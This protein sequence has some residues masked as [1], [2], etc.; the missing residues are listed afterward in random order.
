[1]RFVLSPMF[2]KLIPELPSLEFEFNTKTLYE[3]IIALD[4]QLLKYSSKKI[5][6]GLFNKYG[7][8]VEELGK[9][10]E[11]NE[12]NVRPM[13]ILGGGKNSWKGIVGGVLIVA[14]TILSFIP[15]FNVLGM[16]MVLVGGAFM[17]S[18]VADNQKIPS[19]ELGESEDY[20]STPT[21][22]FSGFSNRLGEQYAVP[23]VYGYHKVAPT[24]ID[25]YNT[26]MYQYPAVDD[27]DNIV[28]I[29]KKSY[30]FNINSRTYYERT[31]NPIYNPNGY[32]YGD[33]YDESDYYTAKY[34]EY[35]CNIDISAT[36]PAEFQN[37]V[38]ATSL[39]YRIYS[40]RTFSAKITADSY[41]NIKYYNSSGIQQ[42]ATLYFRAYPGFHGVYTIIL[43]RLTDYD[44]TRP[45]SVDQLELHLRL[46]DIREYED[47]DYHDG[48][49]GP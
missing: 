15:P 12:L 44:R 26:I 1:M 30:S 45:I 7:I 14:G 8:Q 46:S 3:A 21:Y 34:V 19:F 10:I 4:L 13:V 5:P 24:I 38:G 28:N 18:W 23:V 36:A 31:L 20:E 39:Q 11:D 33:S 47:P 48:E 17:T 40:P 22:N 35:Y 43:E 2:K 27:N 32:Y 37:I 42:T 16:A 41:V 9:E 6:V 49:G 25:F 29:A